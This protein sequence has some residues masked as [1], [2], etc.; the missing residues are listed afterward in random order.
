MKMFPYY[1]G[2]RRLLQ[3]KAHAWERG[4]T[5]SRI[6]EIERAIVQVAVSESLLPESA[7]HSGKPVIRRSKQPEKSTSSFGFVHFVRNDDIYKLGITDNL[8]RRMKELNPDEILN[9]VRCSNYQAIE[10]KMHVHFK[11]RRIPQTEYFRLDVAEVE[12]AHSLMTDL[13]DFKG[14]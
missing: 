5:D 2:K 7:L 4:L 14:R 1:S 12:E 13:A 8:L 10:K 9:A 6:E 11:N 3:V